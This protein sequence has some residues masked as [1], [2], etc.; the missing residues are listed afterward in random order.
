M[1]LRHKDPCAECPWRKNAPAGYL[2]G[3]AAEYYADAVSANEIPPCHLQDKG[4]DNPKSSFCVGA[5]SVA[6]NSCISPHNTD[7]AVEA[8]TVI[9]KRDDTFKWVRDFFKHHTGRDYMPFL[10]RKMQGLK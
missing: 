8:K 2:G 6:A 9:G 5:L 7:G 4:P 1:K 3:H 10:L